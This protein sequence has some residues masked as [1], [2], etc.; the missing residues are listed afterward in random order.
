M[1]AVPEASI[2]PFPLHEL[3]DLSPRIMQKV[4][5]PCVSIG[6]TYSGTRDQVSSRLGGSTVAKAQARIPF[7]FW[8][9]RAPT[10][11]EDHDDT[12]GLCVSMSPSTL[13]STVLEVPAY[14]FPPGYS[15]PSKWPQ[16]PLQKDR[17]NR[18]QVHV[19]WCGRFLLLGGPASPPLNGFWT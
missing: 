19:S 17:G 4:C 6:I 1:R 13:Y 16:A 18:Y 15:Y 10:L 2:C 9:P 3:L 14:P 5:Q 8:F 12:S 7:I 11:T